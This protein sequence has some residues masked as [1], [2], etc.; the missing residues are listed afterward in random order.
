MA[1]ALPPDGSHKA[2]HVSVSQQIKLLPLRS[3][4]GLPDGLVLKSLPAN[5]GDLGLIPRASGQ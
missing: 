2:S 4:R 5:P 3:N 1:T